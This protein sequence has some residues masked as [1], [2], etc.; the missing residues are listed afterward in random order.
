MNGVASAAMRQTADYRINWGIE[1][2]RIQAIA[3]DFEPSRELAQTLW[4]EHVRECKILACLLMPE[5]EFIEEICDIWVDEIQTEEIAQMFCLYLMPRLSYASRKAFQWIAA[6]KPLLQ[7]CGY[8]T[9]CHLM[10]RSELS[11]RS[12][13]ELI[14]QAAT[15]LNN[16]AAVRALQILAS[17][18]Q[19]N[20]AKVKK[21]AD[22]LL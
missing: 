13:D 15:A 4:H 21:V 18:S 10:R 8:L 2:P 12:T 7:T 17:L 6:E 3:A 22:Y 9:L 11:E 14:D 5:D 19:D 1:L 20:A 16:K